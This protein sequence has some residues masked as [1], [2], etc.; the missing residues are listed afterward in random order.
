[1]NVI[2]LARTSFSPAPHRE[3]RQKSVFASRG[4]NMGTVENLYVEEDSRDM[5]FVDVVTNG[6]LGLGR[7]HHLVPV[8]AVSEQD[9]GWITL[10]V[11]QETVERAPIFPNPRFGANE[12][13][14]VRSPNFGE[15]RTREVRRIYLPRR[16]AHR[17]RAPVRH[18]R[19]SDGRTGGARQPWWRRVF[20]G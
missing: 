8:E 2:R 14:Q 10:G 20:G 13:Y 3:L 11:A 5:R 7:K 12:D 16:W 18:G 19:P 9:P 4:R 17:G 6:F 1:M 15:P